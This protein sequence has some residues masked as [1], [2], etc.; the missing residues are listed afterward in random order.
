MGNFTLKACTN[1]LCFE[2]ANFQ[3][4]GILTKCYVEWAANLQSMVTKGEYTN[5]NLHEHANWKIKISKGCLHS[6][7]GSPA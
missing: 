2:E 6:I 1:L 7:T 4:R 5:F 3:I